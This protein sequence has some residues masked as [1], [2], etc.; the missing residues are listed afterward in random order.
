VTTPLQVRLSA[1]QA[2]A[3][4]EALQDMGTLRL[5]LPA[6]LEQLAGADGVTLTLPP[7]QVAELGKFCDRLVLEDDDAPRALEAN[8]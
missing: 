2:A 1:R 6:V 8:S 3:L 4:S 7:A 5:V